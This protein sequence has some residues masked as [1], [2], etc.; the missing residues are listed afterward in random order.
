MYF[1]ECKNLDDVKKRYRI[2]S[3]LFH[4]DHGGPVDLMLELNRYYENATGRFHK[5]KTENKKEEKTKKPTHTYTHDDE[6][7]YLEKIEKIM[8]YA[9]M[10]KSFD[11]NFIDS[12]W[13]QFQAN[14]FISDRQKSAI[15]KIYINFRIGEKV[16]N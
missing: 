2:L 1:D 6:D 11:S 15:D 4:P 9:D 7:E 16:K 3:K 10:F 14:G 12:V 5:Q 13:E 8:K